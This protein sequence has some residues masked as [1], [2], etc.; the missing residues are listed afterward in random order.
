MA[1]PGKSSLKY[2]GNTSCVEIAYDKTLIICDA[3]TGIRVLG[4]DLMKRREKVSIQATILLSHV[5]WDH[6]IGLPFFKPLYVSKNEFV[7]GGPKPKGMNFGEAIRKVMQP[8]YF[9]IPVSAVP[10]HLTFKNIPEKKFRI[11]DV[12]VIPFRVNHP[13]GAFGW[14]FDFPSGKSVVHV[15][16]NE[17]SDQAAKCA[18]AKWACGADILIHDAQYT[19]K[20]YKKRK[21]WGHSPYAYPV[22]I[23]KLAA[24]KKLFLFH[25]DPDASDAELS[26]V[27][28]SARKLSRGFSCEL[29][30]EGLAIAL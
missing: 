14:R 7:I 30:T 11:G 23:A 9:P 13:G 12:D 22:E 20:L 15:T 27:L 19:D 17:P 29:A 2:G 3:G 6:Y 4:E 24:V 5:H 21:G 25:F 1:V 8:P 26:K 18:M 28:L 16:D 10:S